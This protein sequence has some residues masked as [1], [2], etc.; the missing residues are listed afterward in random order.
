MRATS[1][2]N[3]F[4]RSYGKF[5]NLGG[6]SLAVCEDSQQQAQRCETTSATVSRPPV[7]YKVRL[8]G[9]AHDEKTSL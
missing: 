6:G 7:A 1:I 8:L 4:Y 9:W 5:K 2:L 3:C